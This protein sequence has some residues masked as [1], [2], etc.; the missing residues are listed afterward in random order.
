MQ[1]IYWRPASESGGVHVLVAVIALGA[2]LA[3]ERFQRTVVAPDYEDKLAAAKTMQRGLDLVRSH[4][5]RELAAVAPIDL[6]LDP[7]GSGMIGLASSITTTNS[8]SLAA[9]RTTVNPNW[10]AVLVDLLHRANVERGDLVAVGI[11]GSFPALNMAALIAADQLGV[12]TVTIASAGASS[13][14]ANIPGF[15]WLDMEQLLASAEIF[16]SRTV[17]SSLGGTRDR[18]LG[19]DRAGRHLLHDSIEAYGI[20]FIDV[21]EEIASID[22]RM[23]IYQARA[24]GRR[25]AAYINAGGAL[26][27]LGPKSVK[28]L[29]RPGVNLRPHPRGIGVDSVTMRFLNDGVPVINLSKVVPLAE[30]FGLPVEPTELPDVGEGRVFARRSH[31]ARLVAVLLAALAGASFVLLRLEVGAR[32]LAIGGRQRKLERMV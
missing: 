6:E 32:I 30:E 10:A 9:K 20:Q 26:V 29:Y 3:A 12:E 2:L 21:K 7:S 8:G 18:A 27:S 14:G 24:G 22:E 19:M 1:R 4:R 15:G 25:F 23:R 13:F 16:K 11:S 5:V 17:A 28:R 31:D